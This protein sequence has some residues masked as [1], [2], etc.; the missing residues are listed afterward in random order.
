ML[1]EVLQM[2][3]SDIFKATL[4]LGLGAKKVVPHG[5]DLE[6]LLQKPFRTPGGT[7]STFEKLL[8]KP[9]RPTPPKIIRI[10]TGRTI[11]IGSIV[12]MGSEALGSL[13]RQT[14]TLETLTAVLQVLDN[15]S[16]TFSC[17]GCIRRSL[18][19]QKHPQVKQSLKIRKRQ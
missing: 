7:T 10:D 1:T 16:P 4:L 8:E 11:P 14:A 3:T 15:V 13:V 5:S 9:F 17:E 6:R 18:W 2:R 19:S 12:L